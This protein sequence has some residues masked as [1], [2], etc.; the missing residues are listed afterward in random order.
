MDIER[1]LKQDRKLVLHQIENLNKYIEKYRKVCE[2]TT[3]VCTESHGIP[4]YHINGKYLSKKNLKSA[5]II[6]QVQYSKKIVPELEK[7]IRA[8]DVALKIYE[9]K[10]IEK[11]YTEMCEGRRMLVMPVQVPEDDF[12]KNWINEEYEVYDRWDDVQ[13]EYITIKGERVRS[14]SEKMIADELFANNIPYKYEYPLELKVGNTT[15]VFRPDFKVLNRRT[16]Q[17]YIVE[18]LGMMDK[19]GY[20]NSVLNKIDVFEHNGYL[21]GVNMLLLHETT[22][23]PISIPVLRQYIEEYFI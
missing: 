22:D 19:Y 11:I 3:L 12:V 17:E 7:K 13:T 8:I 5:K 18:H 10:R 4:Q 1:K 21:I 20:N 15:K 23:G 14:K 9:G 16:R 6:A 2:D